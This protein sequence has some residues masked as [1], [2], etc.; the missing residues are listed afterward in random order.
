VDYEEKFVPFTRDVSIR[1]VISIASVMRRWIHHMDVK[2]AF[3][4][5]IIE[6]KVYIEKPQGFEVH[7]REYHVLALPRVRWILTCISYL[8]EKTLSYW[9]CT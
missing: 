9:L 8:L 3:L 5:G 4:N 1:V 7:G 2:I 6:E